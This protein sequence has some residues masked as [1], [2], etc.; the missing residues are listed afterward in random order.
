MKLTVLME[1]TTCN[2]GM[3]T[4]HGLSLY[5]EVNGHRILFDT[6]QSNAFVKNAAALGIDLQAVDIA[7]LSH[8]HYD[9]SGGYRK[10]MELNEDARIYVNEHA[11]GRY[12]SSP[13]REIGMGTALDVEGRVVLTRDVCDLG[14]GLMLCTCNDRKP[15]YE[16]NAYGLFKL[17]DGELQEDDFLHEQYLLIQ[18]EGKEIL[19]SGCSHKGILNITEWFKPDV[20]VGGFH[21]KKLDPQGEGKETLDEAAEALRAYKTTYYTCHCTGVEQYEYMKQ[22]MQEQV[23]YIKAGDVLEL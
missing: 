1:N 9:H 6:G 11:S 22:Q 20:L 16:P 2:P 13:T 10:F 15:K 8:A 4:E 3:L 7:I 14:D 12:F 5:I 19:I 23:H 21:F 18:E 17:E